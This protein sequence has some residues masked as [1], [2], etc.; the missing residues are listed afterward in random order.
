MSQ[1][2][3]FL[4]ISSLSLTGLSTVIHLV[5]NFLRISVFLSHTHINI[6]FGST[7]TS[8][9]QV[10]VTFPDSVNGTNGFL[11]I[12]DATWRDGGLLATYFNFSRFAYVNL[13]QAGW[14]EATYVPSS[15]LQS[16]LNFSSLFRIGKYCPPVAIHMM[17]HL[18]SQVLFSLYM[19]VPSS[20]RLFIF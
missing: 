11:E 1:A 18:N 3:Y 7:G 4:A 19:L 5:L 6:S 10:T 20:I 9:N 13:T 2:A 15:I 17:S 16:S 12:R 14:L 8:Y